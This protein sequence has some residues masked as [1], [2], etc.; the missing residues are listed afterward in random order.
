MD[1]RLYVKSALMSNIRILTHPRKAS[2]KPNFRKIHSQIPPPLF[3]LRG[4]TRQTCL[5]FDLRCSANELP[6]EQS[7]ILNSVQSKST[8]ECHF[9]RGFKTL[10][11]TAKTQTGVS[12][13]WSVPV[14][15]L[16]QLLARISCGQRQA[17]RPSVRPFTALT[18][19]T[20]PAVTET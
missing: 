1:E 3:F 20:L 16:I 5:E 10:L 12:G 2:A 13:T 15:L 7:K 4:Q 11:Y 9:T 17:V 19:A 8:V 18:V 6:R 14:A